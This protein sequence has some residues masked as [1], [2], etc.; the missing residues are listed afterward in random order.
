MLKEKIKNFLKDSVRF[1]N[2]QGKCPT[3]DIVASV[4]DR[5]SM[6][7][8]YN[9]AYHEVL[10]FNQLKGYIPNISPRMLSVTLKKLEGHQMV[11]RKLYPEVPPK[12]EYRLTEFGQSMAEKLLDV[13]EFVMERYE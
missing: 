1:Q 8:L 11:E 6:F 13:T 12:V 4:M 7:V 5:W 2:D 10:R 9:L 3:A